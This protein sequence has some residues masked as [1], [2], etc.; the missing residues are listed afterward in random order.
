MTSFFKEQYIQNMLQ[1]KLILLGG[2]SYP[3]FNNVVILAGGAGSGKGFIIDK[4]LG[5]EGWKFDVDELKLLATRAPKIVD[6]LKRSH[7]IDIS[8]Y[9]VSKDKYALKD[10]AA[11]GRLH[12]AVGDILNLDNRKK[13]QM[14][15]SILTSPADRKP[16]LIFDVT[17]KSMDQF[18]KYTMPIQD[19]GYD[20][21]DIHIVWVVNDIQI[22]RKQNQERSRT[23]FDDIL[24]GTHTGAQQTMWEVIN[25]GEELQKYMDGDLVFCW[26]KQN[27]DNVWQMGSRDPN[28]E[29][30]SRKSVPGYFN[31]ADYIYLKRRGKKLDQKLVSASLIDKVRSY[32]PIP[33]SWTK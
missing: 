28:L 20:K 9:D 25:M 2:K 33:D 32:V 6:T 3:K 13:Q 27:E 8:Q 16:N 22:A 18:R 23:V 11:V 10:P 17:M 26:N 5:I 15:S 29:G 21:K 7:G 31:K 4:L 1:E 19:L 24:V 30:G 14:F 12:T